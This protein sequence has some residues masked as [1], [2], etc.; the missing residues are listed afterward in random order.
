VAYD[1]SEN[2]REK[3]DL[4]GPVEY[5]SWDNRMPILLHPCGAVPKGTAPYYR[6]IADARF[7]N[8]FYSDRGVTYKTAAQLSSTPKHCDFSSLSTSP[9]R[10]TC[11]CGS[12]E[13]ASCGRSRGESSCLMSRLIIWV[14]GNL[15]N[16]DMSLETNSICCHCCGIA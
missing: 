6:L 10:T 16:L 2:L 3:F 1:S 15:T 8:K 5:V 11:R 4:S 7:A 14:E 12:D 9:T 13:A